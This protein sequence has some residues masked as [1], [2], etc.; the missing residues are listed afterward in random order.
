MPPSMIMWMTR[1]TIGSVI[2]FLVAS[3]TAPLPRLEDYSS[4]GSR[5]GLD[6]H[7]QGTWKIAE[8]GDLDETIQLLLEDPDPDVQAHARNVRGMLEALKEQRQSKLEEILSEES[9]E[10]KRAS[11]WAASGDEIDPIP[12]GLHEI[13]SVMRFHIHRPQLFHAIVPPKT[14]VILLVKE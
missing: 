14:T 11:R 12:E 10:L 8:D 4:A 5:V 9:D 6:D 2:V 1:I 7:D 13:G 3:C